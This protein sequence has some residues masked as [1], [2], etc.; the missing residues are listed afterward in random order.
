M[1]FF[2]VQLILCI[3][4]QEKK[5]HGQPWASNFSNAFLFIS[6]KRKANF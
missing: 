2:Y 5:I 1:F 3:S 4:P 6:Y